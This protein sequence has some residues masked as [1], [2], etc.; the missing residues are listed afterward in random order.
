MRFG[1]EKKRIYTEKTPGYVRSPYIPI[2]YSKYFP[3]TKILFFLREPVRKMFSQEIHVG[4]SRIKIWEDI[5]DVF[6]EVSTGV[7][8]MKTIELLNKYINKDRYAIIDNKGYQNE[9]IYHYIKYN[10][11]R[12][13]FY[14]ELVQRKYF[15]TC[16]ILPL[17]IWVRAFEKYHRLHDF[18]FGYLFFYIFF[19]LGF[20]FGFLFGFF[21]CVCVFFLVGFVCFL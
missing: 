13:Q 7:C 16:Y 18:K 20:W 21:F 11:N 1:G 17:L 3:H 5:Q 9:L 8:A 19:G 4:G 10:E 6:S 2:V 14:D 15:P 12:D